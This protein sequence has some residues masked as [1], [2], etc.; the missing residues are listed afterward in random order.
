M[1]E[2]KEAQESGGNKTGESVKKKTPVKFRKRDYILTFLILSLVLLRIGALDPIYNLLPQKKA[3]EKP[4]K[5]VA[6]MPL[7]NAKVDPA[8]GN[9][10]FSLVNRG[11]DTATITELKLVNTETKQQCR[12]RPLP[13]LNLPTKITLNFSAEKCAS[14]GREPGKT[15]LL[16]LAMTLELTKK[17]K[18]LTDL[19]TQV[20][21][22]TLLDLPERLIDDFSKGQKEKI[23]KSTEGK[24]TTITPSE[25]E[26]IAEYAG[27]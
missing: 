20:E 23:S 24:R 18:M 1:K 9:I 4:M 5:Y 12:I 27:E 21:E 11:Y 15:I 10:M 14:T 26:L 22:L 3:P 13:P 16:K 7:S 2:K 6:V 25:G 19:D 8:T 17:S